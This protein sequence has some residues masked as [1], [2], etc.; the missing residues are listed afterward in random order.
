MKE[1][2]PKSI[3]YHSEDLVE[4]AVYDSFFIITTV[5]I[6]SKL[7]NLKVFYRLIDLEWILP[8]VKADILKVGNRFPLF[9]IDGIFNM[10]KNDDTLSFKRCFTDFFGLNEGVF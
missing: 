1:F 4:K 2:Y 7:L 5:L 8:V 3:G 10:L 9:I 6:G